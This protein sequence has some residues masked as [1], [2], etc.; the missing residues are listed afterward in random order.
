MLLWTLGCMYLFEL[1]SSFSLEIY[2]GVS[3]LDHVVVLLT[4]CGCTSWQ[5][6][7]SVQGFPFLHILTSTCYLWSFWWKPFGQCEVISHCGFVCISL[8]IS[9]FEHFS[10]DCLPSVC[11]LWKDVCLDLLP[12][13]FKGVILH[14]FFFDIEF[15]ELC[16]DFGY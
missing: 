4:S 9:S 11:F 1:I 2:P 6:Q 8:M 3:M 14:F 7:C 12:I 13:F 16:V 15:Y 5:S 10:C